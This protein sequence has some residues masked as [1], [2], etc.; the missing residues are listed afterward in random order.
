MFNII[1]KAE[2]YQLRKTEFNVKAKEWT[3]KY[4]NDNHVSIL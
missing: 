4:A 1:F 2:E 3:K